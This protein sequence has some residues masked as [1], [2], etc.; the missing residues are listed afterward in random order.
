MKDIHIYI[1]ICGIIILSLSISL[2]YTYNYKQNIESFENYSSKQSTISVVPAHDISKSISFVN[3]DTKEPL[4]ELGYLKKHLSDDVYEK[5]QKMCYVSSFEY[6][7]VSTNDLFQKIENDLNVTALQLR[8]EFIEN[9]VYII[10]CKDQQ[11]D[12]QTEILIGT[13]QVPTKVLI[14]YA[15]YYVLDDESLKLAQ[16][17]R[18]EGIASVKEF[19]NKNA[20]LDKNL[21]QGKKSCI[22]YTL[23][24]KNKIFNNLQK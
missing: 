10:I 14:L 3:S 23:N 4:Q 15:S 7:S 5:I 19:F 12:K 11:F 24:N 13:T 17:Q 16:Y 6:D 18:G 20:V 21:S 9:P 22:I 8:R 1:L 2:Y